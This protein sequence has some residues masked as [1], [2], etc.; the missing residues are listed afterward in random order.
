MVKVKVD[1]FIDTAVL[2]MVSTT[3]WWKLK[4]NEVWAAYIAVGVSTTLWWKLKNHAYCY[5]VY[6]TNS[7]N[8]PMV[9]VKANSF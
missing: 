1:N 9:K 4:W 8:H 6:D 7:F 3:L 5:D 2:G